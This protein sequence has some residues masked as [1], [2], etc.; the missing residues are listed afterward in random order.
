MNMLKKFILI[1]FIGLLLG[2]DNQLLLSKLSQRQSN[3]VLAILQQHG[4]DANRKQDNKNGDSIRVSPRDFV[5][6]VDLLRQYNLPSKD[7]VEIIQ[8]FPGDSLVASP[9]AERTRLLS[10]IEQRLEQS[11]LT[12]PDVINARVHV[13]YPLNGNGAV[14]QAQKVSSLVTYSGNEDPKMMMNK[15]K[16]FLTSSFAETGYD[17]VSVVIV[18][19]P[20]LQYQIKPESDYSTNP[21]LI[22]TIIAVI[23]SLFSALLLLWYRQNKKQQTVI[24]SSEIQPH[25]TVE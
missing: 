2:C 5:I 16:L 1:G 12:I 14:K 15:I 22:S 19:R 10:L 13:S 20:P 24:N 17:N 3:E 4:V 6:A 21:V 9:Q 18:N 8:A 11:L 25:D 7:P 23:I